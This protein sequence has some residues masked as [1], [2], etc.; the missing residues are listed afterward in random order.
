MSFRSLES[1]SI[2]KIDAIYPDK[3][4]PIVFAI[5]DRFAFG[6]SVMIESIIEHADDDLNYDMIIL[7]RNVSKEHQ[8]AIK[9]MQSGKKSISIRF[10]NVEKYSLQYHIF[11]TGVTSELYYRLLIPELLSDYEKVIYADGDMITLTDIAE[12]MR[13]DIGNNLFA[14]VKDICGNWHYYEENSHVKH[15][16]DEDIKLKG[17]ENYI[18]AGLLVMNLAEIRNEYN[19]EALWNLVHSRAWEHHDQDIINKMGEE[20]IYILPFEWNLIREYPARALEYMPQND[21][22]NWEGSFSNPKVIHFV[23]DKKPWKGYKVPDYKLFWKYALESPLL[24][25][26]LD[27]FDRDACYKKVMQLI[28]NGNYGLIL[29]MRELRAWIKQFA[30]KLVRHRF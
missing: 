30:L 2:T 5:D 13:Y 28:K 16:W 6:L 8:D 22:N 1:E 19:Q 11:H 3:F 10:Y 12:L 17:A 15:Y 27:S 7:H 18:N 4:V 25:D 23:S 29:I 9:S 24:A 14:A 21:R 26:A 20:K